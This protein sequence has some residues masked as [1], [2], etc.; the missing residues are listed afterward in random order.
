[1]TIAVQVPRNPIACD[2][3]NFESW[4]YISINVGDI[5]IKSNKL[6]TDSIHINIAILIFQQI[7]SKKLN[8]KKKKK[9]TV[10]YV[11]I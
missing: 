6:D 2:R 5:Y 3:V 8:E 1:M 4:L 10:Q 11:R 9:L 7:Y